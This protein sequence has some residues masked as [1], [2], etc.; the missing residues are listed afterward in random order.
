MLKRTI[1]S[2]EKPDLAEVPKVLKEAL[3]AFF[4]H[5]VDK[6]RTANSILQI[7]KNLED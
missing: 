4:D 6:K 3:S 1:I 2:N 7:F 5:D